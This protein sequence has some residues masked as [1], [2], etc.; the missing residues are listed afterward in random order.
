VCPCVHAPTKSQDFFVV[1]VVVV[2]VAI[3]KT[4]Q[5]PYND[6]IILRASA[7]VDCSDRVCRKFDM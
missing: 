4:Q 2:Q 7:V 6:E 1:V 3:E 5:I